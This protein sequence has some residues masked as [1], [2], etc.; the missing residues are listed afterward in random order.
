MKLMRLL[1]LLAASLFAM[2]AGALP[3]QSL[4][5]LVPAAAVDKVSDRLPHQLGDGPAFDGG[6]R[7]QLLGQRRIESEQEVL[8]L[9]HLDSLISV[10]HLCQSGD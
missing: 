9:G 4:E 3:Q 8:R 5:T 7:L 1:A 6:Y 2:A 10:V